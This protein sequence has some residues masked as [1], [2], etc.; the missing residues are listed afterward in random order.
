[1]K[2]L[3]SQW[4]ADIVGHW[5]G[6]YRIMRRVGAGG[7]GEVFLAHDTQLDRPVAIKR[8]FPIDASNPRRASRLRREAQIHAQLAHPNIVRVYDFVT[9][10]MVT[11]ASIPGTTIEYIVSEFVDGQSLRGL[12][13]SSILGTAQ[14]LEILT[15][16]AR[17]L[18]FAHEHGVVHR[19]LKPD[20]VL[21][22]RDGT[23]RLTDFGIS[24]SALLAPLTAAETDTGAL[25]GTFQNMSPEQSTGGEVDARSDLFSLGIL[26]FEMFAG[27]TPFEGENVHQTLVNIRELAH[28]PLRE[29]AAQAPVALSDLCDRLLAKS[30]DARPHS[31]S[32]IVPTLEAMLSSVTPVRE[33]SKKYDRQVALL[34]VAFHLGGSRALEEALSPWLLEATGAAREAGAEVLS[35]IGGEALVAVGYPHPHEDSAARAARVFRSLRA[36]AAQFGLPAPGGAI[37]VGRVTIH[38][39]EGLRPFLVGPPIDGVRAL[40]GV[41]AAGRLLA[42]EAAQALLRRDYRVEMRPGTEPVQFEVVDELVGRQEPPVGESHFVGRATELAHLNERWA[43][44][45]ATPGSANSPTD[46]S[47]LAKQIRSEGEAVVVEGEAGIGKSRLVRA[48]LEGLA[49]APDVARVAQCALRDRFTPFAPLKALLMSLPELR[50]DAAS[51]SA[52]DRL[53][54]WLRPLTP[55]EEE[56][57]SIVAQVLGAATEEDRKR[58]EDVVRREGPVG[59]ARHFACFLLGLADDRPMILV[60]EDAHWADHSTLQ[61]VDELIRQI[62]RVP[63]LLVI[64]SRPQ[65]RLLAVAGPNAARFA[66]SPLDDR[67]S[68]Q[69]AQAKLAQ[70]TPSGADPSAPL[71]ADILARAEGIPLVIEELCRN[72]AATGTSLTADVPTSLRDSIQARVGRLPDSVRA[73]LELAAAAGREVP[74]D[75][76][77]SA[78]PD[79]A[80]RLNRD[81]AALAALGLVQERGFR[82]RRVAFRHSLMRDSVIDGVSADRRRALHQRIAAALKTGKFDLGDGFLAAQLTAG[83]L[84]LEGART[85]R[86][87]ATA[88]SELWA[89]ESACEYFQAGLAALQAAPDDS[90]RRAEEIALRTGLGK[91]LIPTRGLGA[92]EIEANNARLEELTAKDARP[93]AWTD[94]LQ[95]FIEA[96][97]LCKRDPMSAALG[98]MAAFLQRDDEE[99]RQLAPLVDY[100]AACCRGMRL[101]HMGLLAHAREELDRAAGLRDP[102]LPILMTF[103]EPT[104][105]VMATSYLAWTHLL[106]GD[107]QRARETL[108]AEV[109]RFKPN[110]S[111]HLATL[112]Q[113]AVLAIVAEDWNLA[114]ATA[115]EVIEHAGAVVFNRGHVDFMRFC[116][117]V[118]AVRLDPTATDERGSLRALDDL[119]AHFEAWR[120]EG[121]IVAASLVHCA[122]MIHAGVD[123]AKRMGT[124]PAKHAA[125]DFVE[126]VLN[127]AH[128]TLADAGAAEMH[129][130]IVPELHRAEA[131]RAL[132]TGDLPAAL[133]AREQGR[134]AC[135]LVRDSGGLDLALFRA[136]LDELEV[137]EASLA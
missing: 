60:V 105:P 125:D 99:S 92:R 40:S 2:D 31:A 15:A 112:A 95:Q 130:Y 27:A 117:G 67:S 30:P 54:L 44:V 120:N 37:D 22:G 137:G 52:R 50:A 77:L 88:A 101:V 104:I 25:L 110:S 123:V 116:E 62:V 102:L 20:N 86:R 81:L 126:R 32:E 66:L 58:I 14:A 68:R 45:S 51:H 13:N 75:L 115:R 79:S 128:Q 78:S 103:P 114:R 24:R 97:L 136:R 61:V 29:I 89:Y 39:N 106:A 17:G 90:E 131:R 8:L 113:L 111:H 107:W 134:R 127:W 80:D 96:Y 49:D 11:D 33:A 43:R 36:I 93:R 71:I 10:S 109:V 100:L 7:M 26:A 42:T 108:A 119:W 94:L 74:F 70:L 135:D 53:L 4:A 21:I 34:Q 18:A 72:V 83:G 5:I 28:R 76:L 84:T 48:F 122:A 1:M 59:P 87:A 69:L 38:E 64:T 56:T 3:S 12:L 85:Y 121:R 124:A 19:D 6:R 41:D 23:I 129:R 132:A 133:S 46:S 63:L 65:A 9:D 98:H 35:A 82:S 57:A 47:Q 16:V 55:D 118:A 91:S 73:T